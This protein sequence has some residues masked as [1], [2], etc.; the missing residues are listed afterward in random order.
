MKVCAEGKWDLRNKA[1][2]FLGQT[3]CNIPARS[4]RKKITGKICFLVSH[5]ESSTERFRN[6]QT[7]P[8]FSKFY[9]P[10]SPARHF[11]SETENANQKSL[12]NFSRSARNLYR[13]KSELWATNLIRVGKKRRQ[14]TLSIKTAWSVN[15][16]NQLG[17][18]SIWKYPH[19]SISHPLPRSGWV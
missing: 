4:E 18:E 9:H 12:G 14:A 15:S 10:I 19:F 11:P 6:V 13:L 16:N 8:R 7:R 3:S 5:I 1:L 2:L 17:A